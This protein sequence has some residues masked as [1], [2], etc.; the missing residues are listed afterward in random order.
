MEKGTK[1]MTFIYTYFYLISFSETQQRNTIYNAFLWLPDYNKTLGSHIGYLRKPH[2]CDDDVILSFWLLA[3]LV[4]IGHIP[5]GHSSHPPLPHSA[6]S[7]QTHSFPK[8][9]SFPTPCIQGYRSVYW[10]AC[11]GTHGATGRGQNGHC[12]LINHKLVEDKHVWQRN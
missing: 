11:A 6:F 12:I 4:C 2:L 10:G 1:R 8:N 7:S 5:G 3:A 9:P